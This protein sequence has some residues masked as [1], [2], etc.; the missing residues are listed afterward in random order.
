MPVM[1]HPINSG[2]GAALAAI[3]DGN[4]KMPLPIID[5]TTI[6]VSDANPRPAL[7]RS[8]RVAG[9]GD[10][11]VS[12]I[13]VPPVPR[14][15]RVDTR[16]EFDVMEPINGG[17]EALVPDLE[18]EVTPGRSFSDDEDGAVGVAVDWM[19][20]DS[21][22]VGEAG[23]IGRTDDRQLRHCGA[24]VVGSAGGTRGDHLDVH[25]REAA[26]PAVLTTV[27]LTNDRSP[28][29]TLPHRA[30]HDLLVAGRVVENHGHDTITS[31]G[32]IPDYRD[33]AIGF[34][35]EVGRQ[36]SNAGSAAIG[37]YAEHCR[38][39]GFGEQ[40]VFRRAVADCG[41]DDQGRRGAGDDATRPLQGSTCAPHVV[42]TVV[43]RARLGNGEHQS[44]RR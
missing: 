16:A 11:K 26:Q 22:G 20:L 42:G 3:W 14:F 35:G 5:P 32:G 41:S 15:D 12:D 39:A 18:A 38:S 6:A 27:D 43:R 40:H 17:E 4:A 30:M 2:P 25:V 13:V 21:R 24:L 7:R 33:R 1:D 23:R 28:H 29:A 37:P 34:V 36:S 10:I 31:H 9:G 8:G 44:H 19:A